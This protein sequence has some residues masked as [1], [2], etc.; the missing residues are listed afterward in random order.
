MESWGTISSCFKNDSWYSEASSQS[1]V[2]SVLV[3][4]QVRL[5]RLESRI[6]TRA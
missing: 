2:R 3:K 4:V 1:L 6:V 5:E